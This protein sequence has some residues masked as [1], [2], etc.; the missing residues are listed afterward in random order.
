MLCSSYAYDCRTP[1]SASLVSGDFDEL[2]LQLLQYF[3][4]IAEGLA[5]EKGASVDVGE[6]KGNKEPKKSDIGKK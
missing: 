4:S 3:L 1:A 6:H 2:R 5:E